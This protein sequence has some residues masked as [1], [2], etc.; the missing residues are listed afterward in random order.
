[1]SVTLQ[2]QCGDLSREHLER[3]Y[4]FALMWSTGAILELDDRRKM[5]IWLRGNNSIR[6]NLPDILPD[7][8]DTMFDYHVTPDGM[9]ACINKQVLSVVDKMPAHIEAVP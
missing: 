6:L 4:V 1:M 7:S 2:E 8:E 9:H 5:E 3:L